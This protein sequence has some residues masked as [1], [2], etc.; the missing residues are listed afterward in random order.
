MEPTTPISTPGASATPSSTP[1]TSTP[2]TPSATPPASS[3]A[4]PAAAAPGTG[5]PAEGGQQQEQKPDTRSIEQVLADNMRAAFSEDGVGGEPAEAKAADDQEVKIPDLPNAEDGKEGEVAEA[6]AAESDADPFAGLDGFEGENPFKDF[7]LE[8]PS[9][10]GPVA[11]SAKI[12]EDPALAAALEANPEAK[13]SIFANARKAERAQQYD[14][15]LG[16]PDEAKVVVAGHDAY[17]GISNLLGEVKDGDYGT[18][19][20]VINGMLAQA[21]LKD[22]DGNALKNED[23]TPKTNGTVGRFLKNFMKMRFEMI[24]KSLSPEDEEG[25]LAIDIAMERMGLKA[26][27]TPTGE[28]SDELKQQ[29]ADIERERAELDQRKAR[30]VEADRAASEMR[31]NRRTDDFLDRSVS[32]LMKAAT[33]LDEFQRTSAEGKIR[34]Q[35]S[36]AIK[37]SQYFTEREDIERRPDGPKREAALAKLSQDYIVRYLPKITR[38]VLA[39]AGASAI[40]KQAERAAAHATRSEAAKSEQ[41][42]SLAPSKP[43][44]PAGSDMA[45]VE[46]D[47]TKTLGRRPLTS[48]ILAERMLRQQQPA[49]R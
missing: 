47:L 21:T 18:V 42:G 39:E 23:G 44:P 9:G 41:R 15:L 35:L 22:E 5:S 17:S 48:E 2:A 4:T 34:S 14:E 46:A 27:S 13:S 1:A 3:S 49:A 24:A 8:E 40:T 30:E 29:K 33:G 7:S 20:N 37:A 6:G 16:S 36:K 45:S 31:V 43:A 12:A 10:F 26:T 19:A 25:Q 38:T 11:L 32:T 28:M